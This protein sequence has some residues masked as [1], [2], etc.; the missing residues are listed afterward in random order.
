M[1]NLPKPIFE[2]APKEDIF[3]AIAE[4]VHTLVKQKPGLVRMGIYKVFIF[5]AVYGISYLGIFL[6]GNHTW[7]LFACYAVCGLMMFLIFLNGFHD[8]AHNALFTSSKANHRFCYILE[9]FGSNSFIWRKRHLLLHHPYPNIAHWDIDVKQSDLARIH[10]TAKWLPVHRYQHIYMWFLYSLYTLNWLY[11]R[12][13]KDFFSTRDNYLKRVVRIPKMEYFK[14]FFF[15]VLNLLLLIGAPLDLLDQ[16]AHMILLGWLVMHVVASSF[17]AV[18]L[19]STHVDEHAVF[20]TPAP[21]GQ[22]H[23]T[24]FGHQLSVTKDFSTDSKVINYL[25]GGF[26]LHVAHHLFPGISHSYYPAIT[27]IIRKYARDNNLPYINYPFYNAIRSH[28]RLLKKN[29]LEHNLFTTGEL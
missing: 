28:Y 19:L 13:F 18:A 1:A 16:P 20:P 12:D 8:A 14:L 27:R 25:Y 15:K 10:P 22:I 4:E 6:W 5:L 17:G 11:I 2:K 21:D 24:W 26:S 29:G 3:K 23:N 7:A 9:L